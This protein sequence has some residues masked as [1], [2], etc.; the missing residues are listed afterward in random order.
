MYPK[1]VGIDKVQQTWRCTAIEE[2]NNQWTWWN[3]SSRR[4]TYWKWISWNAQELFCG[5]PDQPLDITPTSTEEHATAKTTSIFTTETSF[6]FG[7]NEFDFIDFTDPQQ[8]TQP[9]IITGICGAVAFVLIALLLGVC[10]QNRVIFGKRYRDNADCVSQRSLAPIMEA[11]T[12]CYQSNEENSNYVNIIPIKV[13][14]EAIY[15]EVE[16]GKVGHDKKIDTKVKYTVHEDQ[17]QTVYAE[18]HH[19]K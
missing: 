5:S 6:T 4:I 11:Q 19:P 7:H 16:T 18:I 1:S 8:T 3:P 15:T 12:N 14:S 13:N 2:R 9:Y 17:L 10:Y